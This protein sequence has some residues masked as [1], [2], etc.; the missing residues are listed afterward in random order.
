MLPGKPTTEKRQVLW[1]KLHEDLTATNLTANSGEIFRL[2]WCS[3]TRSRP[4][5]NMLSVM[6]KL[7]LAFCVPATD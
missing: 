3:S 5:R 6:P 2:A 4:S 7:S 1:Q